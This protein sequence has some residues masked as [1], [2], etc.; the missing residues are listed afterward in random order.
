[1]PDGKADR[2]PDALEHQLTSDSV[3]PRL[4]NAAAWLQELSALEAEFETILNQSAS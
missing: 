2:P 4:P 3:A 1:M